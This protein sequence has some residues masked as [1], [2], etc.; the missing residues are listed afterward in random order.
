MVMSSLIR[1]LQAQQVVY[2]VQSGV[3]TWEGPEPIA[4]WTAKTVTVCA[5]DAAL[6]T[7]LLKEVLSA[8]FVGRKSIFRCHLSAIPASLNALQRR[9]LANALHADPPGFVG[10]IVKF[11]ESV[12]M[13]VAELT[14]VHDIELAY[15]SAYRQTCLIATEDVGITP[16]AISEVLES[17]LLPLDGKAISD[18]RV[19]RN[20]FVVLRALEEENQFVFQIMCDPV[21]SESVAKVM[22]EMGV[23]RALDRVAASQAIGA[24]PSGR[25]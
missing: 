5:A 7:A 6:L 18:V 4:D 8:E 22:D 15:L 9:G 25:S 24:I 17:I 20:T 10:T 12:A 13:S 19:K 14:C 2:V 16:A 11:S 3:V 21:T 1:E 23:R